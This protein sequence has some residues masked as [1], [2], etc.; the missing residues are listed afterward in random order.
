MIKFFR[1]IRQKLIDEGNLKNY[2]IYA[3]GEIFL[4]M[5]GILLALQVNI[6]NQNRINEKKEQKVLSDLYE[7]FTLNKQRIEEKQNL[8]I[9]AAPKLKD[10]LDSMLEG[11]ASYIHLENSIGKGMSSV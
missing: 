7:E 6:W 10:Y 5:I 2:L 1:G 8:R 4:V 11:N 3:I 9:S